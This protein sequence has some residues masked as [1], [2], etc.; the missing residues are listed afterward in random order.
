MPR[1]GRF[2]KMLVLIDPSGGRHIIYR[3]VVQAR[4]RQVQVRRDSWSTLVGASKRRVSTLCKV[5]NI[6]PQMLLG[7]PR[8]PES[9]K[10]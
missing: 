3:I 5:E 4:S 2:Y 10:T 7:N 8:M 1:A 9:L 6:R